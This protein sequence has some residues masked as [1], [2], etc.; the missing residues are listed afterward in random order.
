MEHNLGLNNI[1]FKKAG[2]FKVDKWSMIIAYNK[3]KGFLLPL[4]VVLVSIV[5]I[6]LILIPQMQQYFSSRE[7][8]GQETQKL[9][10]LK[11]N[12]NFLANVNEE[13]LDTN[14]KSLTK[15]LPNEKDFFG[16]INSVS[17]VSSKAGISLSNFKFTLGNL[18]KISGQNDS[19]SPT[20]QM[21][22]TTQGDARLLNSFINE[23][24]K[25][26]PLVEIYSIK[27]KNDKAVLLLQFFY[28]PFQPENISEETPVVELSA[29]DQKLIK[30]ISLW[31]N[32]FENN[33]STLSTDINFT[34]T[35]SSEPTYSPL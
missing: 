32:I 33:E 24:Y 27:H 15:I 6:F 34:A 17:I 4:A 7:M 11:N 30:E 16:I 22:L 28:K 18:S 12:Y 3:Y 9:E 21:E 31:N 10:I 8:L 35:P 23:L 5:V 14:L 25:T 29:K 26:A 2:D 19:I 20:I 1:N 13:V